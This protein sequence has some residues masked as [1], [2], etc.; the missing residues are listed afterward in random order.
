M[1]NP[2]GFSPSKGKQGTTRGKEKIFWPRW[3]SNVQKCVYHSTNVDFYQQG[4]NLWQTAAGTD[5]GEGCRGYAPH[6]PYIK[7]FSS[8]SLLKFVC[9]I[10][11]WRHFLDVHPVLRK[12]LDPPLSRKFLK[13]VCLMLYLFFAFSF[14]IS[15]PEVISV[16]RSV[17]IDE[18][19]TLCPW[20]WLQCQREAR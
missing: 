16:C 10:G 15:N 3:E 8:N 5:L 14:F 7:P 19:Y 2:L 18:F 9:L 17:R 11:Q 4:W 6:P 12:I 1:N 20:W 13:Q